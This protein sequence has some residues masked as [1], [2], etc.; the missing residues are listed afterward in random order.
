MIDSGSSKLA[1]HIFRP[2]SIALVGASDNKNSP[3]GRPLALL[4]ESGFE[5]R[6]YPVNP[7]RTQVQGER[8]WKSLESLPEVP[9]HVYLLGSAHTVLDTIAYCIEAV[10]PVVTILA[11]GLSATST[12]GI[13]LEQKLG[14]MVLDSRTRIL[15][16][17]SLGVVSF[18]NGCRL[19]ANAAC[20]GEFPLGGDLV[21]SHS[22]SIVGALVTRARSRGAGFAG[23]VSVGTELD[24]TMAQIC[25]ATLDDPSVL[26]YV[27]FLEHLRDA[28]ALRQFA[29]EAARRNKSV[30][31][32]KLGRTDEA[33][34]LSLTHT[35]AMGG[36]DQ[37]ADAFLKDSGILR[38]HYLDALPEVCMLARTLSQKRQ[39]HKLR[40]AIVTT[41]GGGAA[42]LVDELALR[43]VPVS[44]LPDDTAAALRTA[45][46]D[47]HGGPILDLTL[48]GTR[49]DIM[50]KALDTLVSSGYFDLV[51]IVLGSSAHSRPI[52]SVEPIIEIT[53]RTTCA[54]AVL[55][56]PHAPVALALLVDAGV[57]AFNT[58]E[59]CADALHTFTSKRERVGYTPIGLKTAEMTGTVLDDFG[60]NRPP[61]VFIDLYAEAF[62]AL[63]FDYP[64]VAKLSGVELAHK[65]DVGGVA[66]GVTS[67]EDL[68]SVMS[69]WRADKRFKGKSFRVQVQ[70]MVRD[71][72]A[73]VLVGYLLDKE[74]GP[75]VT[76]SAG[77]VFAE[78]SD[79]R[80]VRMAPVDEGEAMSMINELPLSRILDGYRGKGPGDKQELARSISA[81]S[82]LAEFARVV[83][84]EINPLMVL[85]IGQGVSAVDVL[86]REAVPQYRRA[87]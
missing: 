7:K 78:L 67:V 86:F 53:H 85:P 43:K 21:V 44:T 37:I 30:V 39:G 79:R 83:E 6:I 25:T 59:V 64:V 22:G 24:L 73:E 71:V 80:S 3:A 50:S 84:A 49:A 52:E 4:R 17:S 60:I 9:E 72:V 51:L 87:G 41:T 26:G 10:V 57:P 1:D 31:A 16:T 18:G 68:L 33:A 58:P 75:V 32:F 42:M 29:A 15:G 8:T 14:A 46:I 76:L 2:Q 19:T 63:P 74:V 27:L 77:G 28:P 48:A 34:T 61:E 38:V 66:L 56:M 65:T 47:Y 62:S 40:T 82:R 69:K 55:V 5:G 81:F 36:D 23:L 13:T 70:P 20:S 11:S 54:V 12:N 45:G 35:G